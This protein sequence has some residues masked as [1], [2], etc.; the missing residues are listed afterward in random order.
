MEKSYYNKMFCC[1]SLFS[2]TSQS[3]N[4]KMNKSMKNQT[5]HKQLVNRTKN[6]KDSSDRLFAMNS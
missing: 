3:K 1:N 2:E 4:E 5:L 6:T